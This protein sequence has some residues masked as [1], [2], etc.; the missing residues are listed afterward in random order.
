[1]LTRLIAKQD[2]ARQA[3]EDI[4]S[5]RSALVQLATDEGRDDLTESEDAEF[6]SLSEQL[7]TIDD[8]IVARGERITELNEEA[9]RAANAGRAIHNAIGIEGRVRVTSEATTYERGNGR[10]YFADLAMSQVNND[11]QAQDRL[12]RHAQEMELEARTNPNR[13]DGQGGHYEVAA[14]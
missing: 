3:R 9:E 4:K 12:R 10:S 1:M 6:R 14:A 5:K 11:I 2:E 13:T 8:E 7:K